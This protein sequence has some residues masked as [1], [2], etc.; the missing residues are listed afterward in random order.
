ML[1]K[2]RMLAMIRKIYLKNLNLSKFRNLMATK[3]EYTIR[4]FIFIYIRNI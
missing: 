1:W 4:I 2:D 3:S